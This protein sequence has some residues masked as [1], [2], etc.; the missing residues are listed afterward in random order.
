MPTSLVPS[1]RCGTVYSGWLN[2]SHPS[3]EDGEVDRRVCFND[4]K[5]HCR[6]TTVI[7][8][9]NCGSYYIYKLRQPSLCAM[10]YCGTD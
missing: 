7:D 1:Y 9:R 6:G 5:N 3:A 4:Y 2:G 10:R 8:V